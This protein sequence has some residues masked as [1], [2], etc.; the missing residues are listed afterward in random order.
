MIRN[1]KTQA[2]LF[3]LILIT[4]G[5]ASATGIPDYPFEVE[6]FIDS[7]EMCDHFRGE[8][9]YDQARAAFLSKM[10]EETCSGTDNELRRLMRKYQDISNIMKVLDRF[11]D[12]VELTHLPSPYI[13]KGACPYEGCTYGTW[14]VIKKTDVYSEPDDSSGIIAALNPDEEVQ[15]VTG[16]VYVIPGKAVV[17]GKPHKSAE[18]LHLSAEIFILDYIGEGYS[19]IYQ[20]GRFMSVKIART[21]KRCQHNPNWRYCWVKIIEEPVSDWW[22]FIRSEKQNVEGWVL[23]KEGSLRSTD[24]LN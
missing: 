13:S 17:T 23:M 14:G 12:N 8:E 7:R 24:T 6:E 22:V 15:A 19:R 4:A 3:I 18:G 10:I 11:E 9:P 21:K 1:I 20:N 2:L 16:D 5:H